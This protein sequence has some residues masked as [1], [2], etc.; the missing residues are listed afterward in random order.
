MIFFSVR[1]LIVLFSLLLILSVSCLIAGCT[2]PGGNQSPVITPAIQTPDMT[3]STAPLGLRADNHSHKR[4]EGLSSA[5]HST[6]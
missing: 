1:P 4:E 6:R 2:S 5:W 3:T